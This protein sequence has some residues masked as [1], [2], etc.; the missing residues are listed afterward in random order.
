MKCGELECLG[1]QQSIDETIIEGELIRT[2]LWS[3][4]IYC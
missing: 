1:I 2:N 3:L 4:V